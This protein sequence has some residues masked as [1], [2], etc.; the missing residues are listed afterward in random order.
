MHRQLLHLFDQGE[1][2]RVRQH[3]AD[4]LEQT[5]VSAEQ[6]VDLLLLLGNV[7]MRL[8]YLDQG[9]AHFERALRVCRLHNLRPGMVRT[10]TARGWAF[11]NQGKHTEAMNDYIEAYKQSLQMDDTDST[12][13]ILTNISF[14]S[15]LRGD[16]QSAFESCQTALK[17]WESNGNLRGKAAAYSTLGGFHI[18]FNE[19]A[20]AMAAY[21]RALEIFAREQ[22]LDWMSLVRCGR[23]YVFQSLGE[24]DKATADLEW[25]LQHGSAHL[26]TRIFY[27]QGL[28]YWAKK[29]LLLAR[30]KLEECRK[31]SQEVGDH[32]HD[33]K[34][35]ADLIE[36]AW[37]FGEYAQWAYFSQQLDELYA[38]REAAEAIR[39]RGSCL[40][41][42]GDLA[43]CAGD[44]AQAVAFYQE[45]FPLLAEYEVHERYTIRSQM[46]QTDERIRPRISGAVLSRLG[47]EL[48]QFWRSH[49]ILVVKYPE[50]LL[51][52]HDWEQEGEQEKTE[53]EEVYISE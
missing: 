43:L 37:E 7:E 19:P 4:L 14:V 48:A 11:R 41:K 35:F 33:Y 5:N 9:V 38:D 47:S 18:R 45:G 23:A 15:T 46:R 52:F 16:R 13:W 17:L 25:A 28:V 12:A 21:T 49:T 40:R 6:H 51:T 8:G 2:A 24:L 36:L 10:L 29:E 42:L 22:D 30:S 53:Q 26:R 34:S 31:L 20:E 39:L 44:Y 3:A 27:S 32:F 50:A 1:Y